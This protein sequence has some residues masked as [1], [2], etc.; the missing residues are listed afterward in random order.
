MSSKW[1]KG[2]GILA[3]IYVSRML[4]MF[5]IFP[6]FSIYAS[7][8]DG[9]TPVLVGLA[10]G[11]YGLSQGLLQ[12]PF[13][14]ASDRFGRKMIITLGLALFV[15]GSLIAALADTIIAMIIGRA[16][17]GMGAIST[18]TLAYTTDITPADKRGKVMAIIGSS[19]GMSFV[20]SLIIGPILAK[21]IGVKGLFFIIAIMASLAFLGSL[22]LP[23]VNVMTVSTTEGY[24]DNKALYQASVA[25]FM[26]HALFTATFIVLPFI[27]VDIIADKGAYWQIYLPA[28]LIALGFMRYKATPHALTFGVN[29]ILLTIGLGLIA[30]GMPFWGMMLAIT[31][32]FIAFYRLETGLPYW[33]ANVADPNTR[34]KAMGIYSTMQFLGSFVG[35]AA[36]GRLWQYFNHAE[37][38]FIVLLL[39]SALSG[40][41]LLYLGKKD[42]LLHL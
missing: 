12:I 27:L 17:Q 24:C 14:L 19:I 28:N 3:G 34:G 1:Q 8:L 4:G 38:L 7:G 30:M 22:L 26:T 31:V 29:F 2:I 13:A 10:L 6:V 23:R 41:V 37:N 40:M 36:G 21:W 5:M 32:F 11:V 18:V 39:I 15:S 42:T 9:A 20:F 33:V 16:I 35:G 25:I